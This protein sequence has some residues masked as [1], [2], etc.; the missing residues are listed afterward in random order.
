VLLLRQRVSLSPPNDQASSVHWH[1]PVLHVL[2]PVG[3][4][5]AWCYQRRRCRDYMA[6]ELQAL[7]RKRTPMDFK[8]DAGAAAADEKLD[9]WAV[10]VLVFEVAYGRAPFAAAS[11]AATCAR[12]A[13]GFDGAFPDPRVRTPPALRARLQVGAAAQ[14][15]SAVVQHAVSAN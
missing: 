3:V 2:L 1:A 8:A 4:H 10:G 13:A 11:S 5:L 15:C 7:P 9:V 14:R 6:P 12:I